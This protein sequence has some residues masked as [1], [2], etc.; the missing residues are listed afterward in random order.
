VPIAIL[1][2]ELVEVL[3]DFRLALISQ[4]D[5]PTTN[6]FIGPNVNT[7]VRIQ[8]EDGER[9]SLARSHTV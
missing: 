4:G 6:I 5:N 1:P 8:D 3:E 9:S 2:D 7:Q